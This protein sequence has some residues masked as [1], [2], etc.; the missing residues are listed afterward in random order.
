VHTH[1]IEPKRPLLSNK[2][3]H[4]D[5]LFVNEPPIQSRPLCT[6][7][8]SVTHEVIVHG[9]AKSAI[10]IFPRTMPPMTLSSRICFHVWYD[11]CMPAVERGGPFLRGNRDVLR[12]PL[13]LSR[14]CARSTT[15]HEKACA[16]AIV[17]GGGEVLE[18]VRFWKR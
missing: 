13:T 4:R 1:H 10:V 11:I 3:S 6:V 7:E 9:P 18:E 17:P 16:Q 12:E 5:L 2:P 14:H 8:V 15:S